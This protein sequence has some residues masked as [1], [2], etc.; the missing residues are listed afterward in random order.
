MVDV[1]AKRNAAR[2][3][4]ISAAAMIEAVQ[5]WA[6]RREDVRALAL[7]GSHARGDARGDSD[8]DFV[9]LCSDPTLYLQRTD[10]LSTFGEVA[11]FSTEDWGHVQSVRVWYRNGPEVEFGITGL[12]WAAIPP[13][14]GTSEVLRNGSSILVD[15]DGSLGRVMQVVRGSA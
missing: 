6:Q 9:L 15:R 5:G 13:D 8:I 7:V 2:R 1:K 4:S 10:W 11:R 12:E 14:R 3:R